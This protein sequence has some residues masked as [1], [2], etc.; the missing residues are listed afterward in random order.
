MKIYVILN[1]STLEVEV[2][3]SMVDLSC[4]LSI[5]YRSAFRYI[6][7]EKLVGGIWKVYGRNIAPMESKV[8]EKE[9]KFSGGVD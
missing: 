2:F 3:R 1:T 4:R 8:R 6:N 9:V 5:G 7:R